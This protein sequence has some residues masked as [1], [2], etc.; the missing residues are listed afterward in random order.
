MPRSTKRSPEFG[1]VIVDA[2]SNRLSSLSCHAHPFHRTLDFVSHLHLSLLGTMTSMFRNILSKF[3]FGRGY[4]G[5]DLE[6][7]KFFEYPPPQPGSSRTKRQVK[8]VVGADAYSYATGLR[9]LPAQWTAWLSHTRMHPP[10]IQEL[11]IDMAR[12]QRVT[13]LAAQIQARDDEERA[14]QIAS[15]QSN[16]SQIASPAVDELPSAT[17]PA[18]EASPEQLRD[19]ARRKTAREEPRDFRPGTP[20]TDAPEAWTP[21]AARRRG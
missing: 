12:Q 5:R 6:G 15:R 2:G 7:N 16:A 18:I 8:Y 19:A 20:S 13:A 4:V 21:S 3:R 1:F 17:L 14:R 10:T 11:Q 9:R